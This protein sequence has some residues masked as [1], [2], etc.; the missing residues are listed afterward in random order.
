MGLAGQTETGAEM[1]LEERVAD[2]ATST[3]LRAGGLA[4]ESGP[5]P[6]ILLDDP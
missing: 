4:G 2:A 6:L 1:V 5:A 3:A